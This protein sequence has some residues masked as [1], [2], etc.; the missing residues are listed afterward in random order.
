MNISLGVD[1]RAECQA[2]NHNIQQYLDLCD[3]VVEYFTKCVINSAI[4]VYRI[5]TILRSLHCC[6]IVVDDHQRQH[7]HHH[8]LHRQ[9]S[10]S[11]SRPRHRNQQDLHNQQIKVIKCVGIEGNL[12]TCK[13]NNFVKMMLLLIAL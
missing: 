11:R 7:H 8:H 1:E 13:Q 9:R 12:L 2:T 5:N 4:R 10:H 3:G 6:R